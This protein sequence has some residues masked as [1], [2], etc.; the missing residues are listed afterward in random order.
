[1]SNKKIECE[2]CGKFKGRLH[3]H[4]D[5]VEAAWHNGLEVG[6]WRGFRVGLVAGLVLTY[7]I[8]RWS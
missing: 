5:E 2:I 4:P 8:D 6:G 7:L 3:E 1:M